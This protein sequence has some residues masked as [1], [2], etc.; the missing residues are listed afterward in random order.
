MQP[1]LDFDY[2]ARNNEIFDPK[3]TIL[4]KGNFTVPGQ[5]QQPD[6]CHTSYIGYLHSSGDGAIR[7]HNTCKLWRCP[8][9]YRLKT[10]SEVFKY[11][12][13]LECYSLVT[14]DR[15]FRA[16]ASISNEQ[17]RNLTLEDYRAFRR[18]SKDRLL[19]CGVTAGFKLD[20]PF[21]IKKSVQ[22]AIR[23]LCG[24]D[25]T[26]GGFWDF[27]LN[28]SSL[29]AI[30]AYLD[31]DFKTWRDLV[32]FSPHIHS[33]LFPGHQK[34]TGDKNIILTKLQANDGSYTLDSV[35]DVVKHIRYL[36][37]HCGILIN[38]NESRLKPAGVF[39][40]LHNWK[41]E[42]YL[43]PEEIQDIQLAVLGVL[44][45]KRT[46]PYTVDSE[47]ELC[48]L[49]EE[50]PSNEK[51]KDLGYLPLKEFVAYDES[52]GECLDAWLKSIRNPDNAAYVHYLLSEYS[53]ILKDDT[54]PQKM[55]RLF[56]DGL[57]DP[58]DSFKI[59]TLD[60]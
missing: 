49:G 48:Y 5:G 8:S 36:V 46:K 2:Q 4:N 12:V 38:V 26:S 33:L 55:R 3:T 31:S 20:H 28:P 29:T 27:I 45:E 47:G 56:L 13:L 54:I 59:T 1:D 19:R 53:R 37:T 21:R 52:T 24:E 30:N 34:I 51:L 9:C 57:R 41:P 44:N 23:V 10:D 16:V 6:Y 15:P 50:S 25:T 7:L 60:V 17:A 18:N 11:A 40:N 43:T 39:G 35:R 58:P 14:G 32:N 22:Q 42:E